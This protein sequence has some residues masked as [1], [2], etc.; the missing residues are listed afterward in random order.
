MADEQQTPNPQPEPVPVLPSDPLPDHATRNKAILSTLLVVLLLG[1]VL[2]FDPFGLFTVELGE[3]KAAQP[4]NQTGIS[5]QCVS[6]GVTVTWTPIQNETVNAI[7]RSTNGGGYIPI[8]FEEGGPPF[9][10]TTFTDIDVQSG[11][12]YAYRIYADV[13]APPTISI[14]C[15]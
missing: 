1:G 10:T 12:Q 13:P 2:W 6:T 3:N 7:E 15:P 11:V 14:R 8:Y 5:A 4:S 9:S